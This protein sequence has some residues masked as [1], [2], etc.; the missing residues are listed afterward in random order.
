MGFLEVVEKADGL[1]GGAIFTQLA[2]DVKVEE[3]FYARVVYVLVELGVFGF[4]T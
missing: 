2:E 4:V 1:I 3:C